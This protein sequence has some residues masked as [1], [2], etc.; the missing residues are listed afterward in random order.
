MSLSDFAENEL[1]DALLKNGSFAG[2]ATV[3]VSL[4]AGDC[5]ENG[6]NE[7]AGGSYVRQASGGFSTAA[8]GTTDNDALIDFAGMPAVGGGGVTH[9]GI[10]DLV[11]GGNFLIGGALTA[12][13]VVSA[14][15]TLRIPAG[16]LDVTLT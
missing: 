7:V 8:G 11:S 10:W 13:R 15:D 5:G 14:G 4:H 16:D 3:Y 9:I 6:A 1:L 2:G 12:A